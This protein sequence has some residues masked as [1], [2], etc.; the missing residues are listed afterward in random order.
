MFNRV[1]SLT[2]TS[3]I[4]F[5]SLPHIRLKSAADIHAGSSEPIARCAAESLTDSI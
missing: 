1:F 2:R 4:G 3:M 5:D